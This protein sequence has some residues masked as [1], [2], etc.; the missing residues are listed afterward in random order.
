MRH[1]TEGEQTPFYE[2]TGT[3]K[4]GDTLFVRPLH[5]LD[6]GYPSDVYLESGS[7]GET[8]TLEEGGTN[9]ITIT[10]RE[11]EPVTDKGDAPEAEA[12]EKPAGEGAAEPDS[13]G[14][15]TEE[16]PESDRKAPYTGDR[17][18]ISIVIQAVAALLIGLTAVRAFTA[19][20][21]TDY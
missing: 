13:G 2:E 21:P 9:V 5:A 15:E 19:L 6:E 20:F 18:G 11:A 7:E 10:Y 8:I 17:A 1:I 3:G 12:E 14:E 4:Y 16:T